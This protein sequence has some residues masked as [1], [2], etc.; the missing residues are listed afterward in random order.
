[1]GLQELSTGRAGNVFLVPLEKIKII[2]GR[3]IRT[4][5]I[6][7]LHMLAMQLIAEGQRV[8]CTVRYSKEEDV[9]EIID[10]ERRL[11][12][13]LIARKDH[14]WK[15]DTLKCISEVAGITE[16]KRIVN[17]LH[18]NESKPLTPMERA[19]AYQRLINMDYTPTMIAVSMGCSSAAVEG[20]LVLAKAPEGVQKAVAS[21]KMSATAGKK[22]AKA[23]PEK[24]K[25]ILEKIE[26]GQK[27]KTKDADEH[28]TQFS[29]T[30]VEEAMKGICHECPLKKD[31]ILTLKV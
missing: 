19:G 16:D 2:P 1:M 25:E 14:K 5:D 20:F 9:V 8:P 7:D 4:E 23:K 22:A 12:A 10:G 18:A 15:I 3:N 30:E 21:G 29:L 28:R 26:K 24:Q 27:V 31:L 6:G 11:R 17:M 13:A